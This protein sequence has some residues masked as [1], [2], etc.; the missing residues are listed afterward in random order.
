MVLASSPN[1]AH[2]RI[3]LA[4]AK[5]RFEPAG[6]GPM[7]RTH[8]RWFTPA[9][10]R[11]LFD[12]AGFSVEWVGPVTPFAPRTRLLSRLSGG[13]TDHLFMRQIALQGRK[14]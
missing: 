5:G 1:I 8:L 2:W 13:R 7:D 9:T 10:F 4:L 11:G 6:M 12:A 3:V 14:R